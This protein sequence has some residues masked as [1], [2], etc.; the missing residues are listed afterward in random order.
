LDSLL[1][2]ELFIGDVTVIYSTYL[3]K[4]NRSRKILCVDMKNENGIMT[5][6]LT[7]SSHIIEIHEKKIVPDAGIS[8]TNF[9]I[10]PKSGYECGYCDPVISLLE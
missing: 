4:A 3:D 5:V 7:I 2:E 10:L 1:T 9:K 8:F 6:T